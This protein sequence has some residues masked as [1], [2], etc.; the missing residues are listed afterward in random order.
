MTIG[1]NKC[2]K[3]TTVWGFERK[4]DSEGSHHMDWDGMYKRSEGIKREPRVKTV[5][6]LKGQQKV[7][8][9]KSTLF[10]LY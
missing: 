9:E 6:L 4:I 1:G 5:R 2:L 3:G 10:Y 7:T 8:I